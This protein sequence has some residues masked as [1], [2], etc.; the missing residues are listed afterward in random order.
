M[1]QGQQRRKS[2]FHWAEISGTV[3]RWKNTVDKAGDY[4]ENNFASKQCCRKLL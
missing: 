2:N 4:T 1:H 3:H